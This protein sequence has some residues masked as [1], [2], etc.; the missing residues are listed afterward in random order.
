MIEIKAEFK[1]AFDGD[2]RTQTEHVLALQFNLTTDPAATAAELA[3]RVRDA[4]TALQTGFVGT[5]YL[6]FVLS[7]H[8]YTEL[9]YDLLLR[10]EYPGWLYPVKK[11]ATLPTAKRISDSTWQIVSGEKISTLDLADLTANFSAEQKH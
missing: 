9:A 7:K 4:G 8:G 10:Q 3:K 1:A 5:P 2:F 6:L 11:G